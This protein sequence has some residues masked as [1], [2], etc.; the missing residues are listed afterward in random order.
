[1]PSNVLPLHLK[2]TF[3]PIIWIFTKGDGIK[4]RLSFN[5]FL[6]YPL[7]NYLE[8]TNDV[9]SNSNAAAA[10]DQIFDEVF[11]LL[12]PKNV[13]KTDEENL[14]QNNQVI[15][16]TTEITTENQAIIDID[17]TTK[18]IE[19]GIIFLLYRG[20][21]NCKAGK[22][23]ALDKFSGTLTLQGHNHGKIWDEAKPIGG[24]NLP[25]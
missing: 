1:M 4:S 19:T 14:A 12:E 2:Q 20:V 21:I 10:E 8:A 5:F 3:P 6:L 13:T 23:A 18:A 17:D 11:N 9:S 7:I 22:A 24:R 25:S 15:S 16:E